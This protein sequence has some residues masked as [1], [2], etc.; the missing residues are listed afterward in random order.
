[1]Q[2]PNRF[3]TILGHGV[4]IAL[5]V[6][7]TIF[8]KERLAYS[9]MALYIYKII[10]TKTTLIAHGRFIDI[11]PQFFAV[12]AVKNCFALKWVLLIYSWSLVLFPYIIFI[13]CWHILRS[14]V[15]SIVILMVSIGFYTH[16]FY[17]CSSELQLGMQASVLLWATLY[18][19]KRL[20]NLSILEIAVVFGVIPFIVFAH[21]LALLPSVFAVIFFFLN[22]QQIG[23]EHKFFYALVLLLGAAFVFKIQF[24][25]AQVYEA[26]ASKLAMEHLKQGWYKA[27]SVHST[28]Y[29]FKYF[30]SCYYLLPLLPI[31]FSYYY[32]KNKNWLKLLLVLGTTWGLFSLI[33]V[34]NPNEVQLGYIENFYAI[35]AFCL[36]LPLAIDYL[37]NLKIQIGRA[38]V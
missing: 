23:F 9:D 37:P 12:I 14:Q 8:Y 27:F 28:R 5:L 3:I 26:N 19:R 30:F 4:F 20:S 29:M 10:E 16:A 25:P 17:A 35:I 1:M 11:I 36:A 24:M 7:S 21:P 34:S 31:C 2:L 18:E 15:F 32:I 33:Q 38:H 22:R 13:Y 6:L